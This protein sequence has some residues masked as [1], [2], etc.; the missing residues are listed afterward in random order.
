MRGNVAI[1]DGVLL[2]QDNGLSGLPTVYFTAVY[3]KS[4]DQ[5]RFVAQ[6]D[7]CTASAAFLHAE[8]WAVTIESFE[9]LDKRTHPPRRHCVCRRFGHRAL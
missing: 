5:W 2:S 1:L 4:E 8:F 3:E 6:F 7:H 9:E